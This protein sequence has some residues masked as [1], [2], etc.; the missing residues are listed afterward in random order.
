MRGVTPIVRAMRQAAMRDLRELL[1]G[2]IDVDRRVGAEDDVP[3]GD[4]H[5][6][7][8]HELRARVRADHLERG[9]DRLGVVQVHAGEQRV[10]VAAR[11]HARAEVVAVEEL[12]ARFV[13]RESLPLAEL[14]HVVRVL[15]ALA[16]T[17]PDPR[18]VMPSSEMRC[19]AREVAGSSRA[20]PS[21][22][23]CAMPSSTSMRGGAD[24][25]RL[26]A[27]GEDDALR[28]RDWRG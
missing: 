18:C 21:R 15:V 13:E 16:A 12:A 19:I 2:G 25:L 20:S 26:V 27:L 8:A 24:D 22:I 4:E 7:A 6:H 23:G 5:V 14:P 9:P 17:S 1:G 10:R 3:L 11:D 28:D